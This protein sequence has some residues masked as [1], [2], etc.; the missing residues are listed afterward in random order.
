MHKSLPFRVG[1][2]IDCFEVMLVLHQLTQFPQ[3]IC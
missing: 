2:F 3:F 1:N